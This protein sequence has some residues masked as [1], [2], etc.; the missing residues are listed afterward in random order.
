[1]TGDAADADDPDGDSADLRRRGRFEQ[2]R[3]RLRGETGDETATETPDEVAGDASR[4]DENASEDA[5]DTAPDDVDDRWPAEVDPIP[6]ES[7]TPASPSTTG[8][9]STTESDPET[10]EQTEQTEQ[11]ESDPGGTDRAE[12]IDG[13][14]M[15]TGADSE[16]DADSWEWV[17]DEGPPE[18]GE[19]GDGAPDPESDTEPATE[20]DTAGEP[21]DADDRV[22]SAGETGTDATE[23]DAVET[24]G[25]VPAD[26]GESADRTSTGRI[27]DDPT[28]SMSATT[29]TDS[30][31]TDT[32]SATT[33]T[34]SS[35]R[36]TRSVETD[37]PA[38]SVEA[39]E[40]AELA[41]SAKT[42]SS[43]SQEA[44]AAS[45][46][47]ATSTDSDAA[48]SGSADS[49]T[50]GRE[51]PTPTSP[52]GDRDSDIDHLGE[53]LADATDASVPTGPTN[54]PRSESVPELP[55]FD[56]IEPGSSALVLSPLSGPLS[57]AACGRLLDAGE[58]A[59]AD[60]VGS[61]PADEDAPAGP[62]ERNVLLV[63]VEASAAERIDVCHRAGIDAGEI[64][65]IEVGSHGGSRSVASETTGGGQSVSVTRVS[66]PGNLSKLGI[67]ITKQLSEWESDGR[68]IVFCLHSLT[69]L[70]QAV[71]DEKLFR[72]LHVLTRRLAASGCR[73][74]FHMDPD[75]HHEMVVGTVRPIFDVVV[76]IGP[77]GAVDVD[78]E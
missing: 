71:S 52:V 75:A 19:T 34:D 58:G 43:D 33:D 36:D 15:T 39:D 73:A 16:D 49:G 29:D 50:A 64:A 22:W 7:T 42:G 54:E 59:A 72:F 63:A 4:E 48:E 69:A 66:R 61:G 17:H 76:R 27:W 78:R 28:S 45:A 57:T 18:A 77:N 35:P 38:E 65:A 62:R 31:T 3:A 6:T 11:T 8:T 32:D 51:S 1:M 12:T 70:Q 41:E 13:A 14:K 24:Q 74:H 60:A 21:G 5:G 26:A 25:D 56:A 46:I 30:A 10:A 40:P 44:T 37:E 68:P 55:T 2:L 53:S 9:G 23:T 67:L 20:T 47:E